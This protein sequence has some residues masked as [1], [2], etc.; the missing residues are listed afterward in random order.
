LENKNKPILVKSERQFFKEKENGKENG[1]E[2]AFMINSIE[3]WLDDAPTLYPTKK[4]LEKT[5]RFHPPPLH[6]S[7]SIIFFDDNDEETKI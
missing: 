3:V 5:T 1:K 6:K 7:G 4:K 2:Q